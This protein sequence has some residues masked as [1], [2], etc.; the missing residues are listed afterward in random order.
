M[1]IFQTIVLGVVEGLTEFLPISSTGHLILVSNWM[2]LEQ[3]EFL[4]SFEIIIQ[5]GAIM[6]VTALY[7]KRIR[8][9]RDLWKKVLIGFVPT[10][11][12]GYV[13]Y[14]V[15]KMFLIG[16][17]LVVAWS[18]VLGGVFLIF[19]EQWY[20]KKMRYGKKIED[21]TYR[22]AFIIGSIQ[23]LAVVPGV[24]RSAATIVGGLI[25][26]ISREAIV[27]FSFLLAVPIIGAA[28]ILDLIKIPI[29]F[30]SSQWG[31]IVL[32]SVVSFIT[33]I[34]AIKYFIA[35]VKNHTFEWFGYYRVA[36]GGLVL[37]LVYFVF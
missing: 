28:A 14:N 25:Q 26:N 5:L 34:I 9:S 16:N 7:T 32:G 2:L 30:T 37:I 29:H 8:A 12:I 36:L 6:A 18:L 1:T 22:E 33:A 13:L 24:S 35:F 31:H 17:V 10:A 15:V 3:T 21:I 19:F 23:S 20:G 4:K 27:E 11:V